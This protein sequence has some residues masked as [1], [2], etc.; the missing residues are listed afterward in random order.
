M[1]AFTNAPFKG[2]PASVC[3]VPTAKLETAAAKFF[4]AIAGEVS[5]VE[6]AFVLPPRIPKT[7]F[8]LRFFTRVKETPFCGHAA[9]AA[10]HILSTELGF[11]RDD[12]FFS[13]ETHGVLRIRR[14]EGRFYE[15][16][17]RPTLPTTVVLTS[18]ERAALA[19][20]LGINVDTIRHTAIHPT[21]SN[22]IVSLT[23][24]CFVTSAKP[25]LAK[26]M[27]C[28]KDKK[29]FSKVTITAIPQRQ[30]NPNTPIASKV[31]GSE[32]ALAVCGVG[33]VD[34]RLTNVPVVDFDEERKWEEFDFVTR[35]FAP[36]IGI[37][38]DAVSGASHA[39]LAKHWASLDTRIRAKTDLRC[40]QPSPRTGELY[41]KVVG[42]HIKIS[43]E[44]V[45]ITKGEMIALESSKV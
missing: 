9:L 33:A 17:L 30:S 40:F 45:T 3:I 27:E 4:M 16:D 35:L 39:V 28:C 21:S 23:A 42:D 37:N 6:T 25:R 8:H 10:A 34:D 29:G 44:A 36:W 22:F 20:A 18:T 19:E 26:L 15:L 12:I 5:V 13:T 2:N 1:N 11:P 43:G 32:A 24:A 41:I 38:E 31:A 7:D 14:I